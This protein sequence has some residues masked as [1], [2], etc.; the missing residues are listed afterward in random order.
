M[1]FSRGDE[2]Q[3]EMMMGT[4]VDKHEAD[5]KCAEWMDTDDNICG[6]K[7]TYG[8]RRM[9]SSPARYDKKSGETVTE[10]AK[11]NNTV[12]NPRV[13][14]TIYNT[15]IGDS[16]G[17]KDASILVEQVERG[18]VGKE[19]REMVTEQAKSNNTL[20][21]QKVRQEKYNTKIGEPKS[22]LDAS[23]QLE[24]AKRRE[25]EQRRYNEK[26]D[27][28]YPIVWEPTSETIHK[29]ARCNRR[30]GEMGPKQIKSDNTSGESRLVQAKSDT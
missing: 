5:E 12:G 21:E 26:A 7:E 24:Q 14:L 15:K 10:Q 9:R 2:E 29:Q 28:Q 13:R 30:T 23:I 22:R 16:K 18:E 17:M 25:V 8:G 1:D 3:K 19:S 6:M 20:G 11:S 4:E 27:K